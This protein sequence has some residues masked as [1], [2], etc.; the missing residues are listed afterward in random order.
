MSEVVK[1]FDIGTFNFDELVQCSFNTHVPLENLHTLLP[2]THSL[3]TVTFENDNETW[4][5]KTFY[6]KLNLGWPEFEDLYHQFIIDVVVPV[7]GHRDFIYQARPTFRVHVPENKSV[8]EFH[9]D[10]DY[11]HQLGE[12]NFSIAVTNMKDTSAIWIESV[13]GLG[14]Y[15]PIN[16]RKG[17][18]AIFDGNRCRH[19][20]KINETG[21]TRVSFDFRILPLSEYDSASSLK[22]TGKGKK[23]VVG[24]YY[25]KLN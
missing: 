17:E 1:K 16:M 12:I 18:F 11:N 5:H 24:D 6:S 22:S 8:G 19:G 4:F 23:M 10:H 2:P 21:Y 9:R 20:N 25:A 13:P 7:M 14:D 3:E 15:H